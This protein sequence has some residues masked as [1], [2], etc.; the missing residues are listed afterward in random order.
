MNTTL[1][2]AVSLAFAFGVAVAAHSFVGA[3]AFGIAAG[4]MTALWIKETRP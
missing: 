2:A 1:L 4:A 3:A